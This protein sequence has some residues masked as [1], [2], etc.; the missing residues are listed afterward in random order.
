MSDSPR[1]YKSHLTRTVLEKIA[2]E[3]DD[4][5]EALIDVFGLT[6]PGI[7]DAKAARLADLV[8]TLLPGLYARWADMFADKLL[9]TATPEQ[10]DD[11]CDGS[12]ANN[13]SIILVYLMFMESERME[14]QIAA[15]LQAYAREHSGDED[16]G[17]AVREY[18]HARL[19]S[20]APGKDSIQ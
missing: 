8:P 17:L 2:T 20:F 7:D 5:R 15:D 3:R 11:L 18:V 16:M 4:R 12:E 1:D 10:L 13:A 9:E 14:Q 6:V 19:A